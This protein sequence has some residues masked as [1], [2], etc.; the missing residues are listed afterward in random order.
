MRCRRRSWKIHVRK[1]HFSAKIFQFKS[2]LTFLSWSYKGGGPWNPCLLF[3]RE[4]NQVLVGLQFSGRWETYAGTEINQTGPCYTPPN[5]QSGAT[6][7]QTPSIPISRVW[8]KSNFKWHKEGKPQ[9]N[10]DTN[11][12]LVLI[13]HWNLFRS[14][15]NFI[16]IPSCWFA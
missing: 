7:R 6:K 15:M 4:G 13:R 9:D 12:L 2:L 3:F 11:P 14:T 5:S 1:Q 16:E 10:V 8:N